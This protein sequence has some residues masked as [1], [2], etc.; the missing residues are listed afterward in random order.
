MSER[1]IRPVERTD[2]AA[3][4]AICLAAFDASENELVASL[5][6][7]VVEFA[8]CAH[9]MRADFDPENPAA[10][11]FVVEEQQ[12]V[13]GFIGSI[14]IGFNAPSAPIAQLIEPLVVVPHR[15]KSG[16]GKALVEHLVTH[17]SALGAHWL[18]VYG[19]PAYY[20][21]LGFDAKLAQAFIAPHTLR[22]PFGWQVMPLN[23]G[24][25]IEGPLLCHVSPALDDASLW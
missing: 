2:L 5:T 4:R 16:V 13:V 19:D 9:H 15:Q 23:D 18:L 1:S 7:Q 21:R 25:R 24:P 22:Y 10:F 6:E 14:A 12:D 3:V 17:L 8:V 11:G 20:A